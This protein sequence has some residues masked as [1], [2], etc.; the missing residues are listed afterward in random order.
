MS[1]QEAL[2][3][4]D[5]WAYDFIKQYFISPLW[6]NPL[7]NFIEENCLIFEDSEENKFEYTKIFK[8][9]V[10]LCEILIESIL[11]DTGISEKVLAQCIAKG[12]SH[13]KDAKIFKQLLVC[14][15]FLSFK[16]IMVAKNK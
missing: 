15:N 3:E 7:I 2:K 8:E 1:N 11:V 14:D 16:S 6:R 9:F 13:K 5:A 10:G 12:L 4:E